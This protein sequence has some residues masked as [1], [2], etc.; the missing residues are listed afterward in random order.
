MAHKK[1]KKRTEKLGIAPTMAAAASIT[2]LAPEIVSAAKEAGCEAFRSR[3]DV[4]CDVLMQWLAEH[5]E[6]A[7]ETGVINKPL[8]EALKIRAERQTK[9]HKL[10]ELKRKVIPIDEVKRT[11]TR[12][13]LA[14][15]SKLLSSDKA[16]GMKAK[17]RLGITEDQLTKLSEIVIEE[18]REIAREMS[19]GEWF[20]QECPYCEK[21]L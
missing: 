20:L 17:L 6:I 12:S 8:E 2:G 21:A 18:H 15:K 1:P 4:N 11:Y 16:I 13:V 7:A 3:G 14:A 10:A 9:E 19:K 5:P